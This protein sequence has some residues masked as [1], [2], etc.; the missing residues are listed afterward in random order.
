MWMMIMTTDRYYDVVDDGS[1]SYGPSS[2]LF[3]AADVNPDSAPPFF[4]S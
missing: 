2:G 1:S 4:S 3:Y